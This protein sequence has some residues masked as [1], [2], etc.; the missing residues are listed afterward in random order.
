MRFTGTSPE[1]EHSC[2]ILNGAGNSITL[3]AMQMYMV[4][5][6]SP[7]S[8]LLKI[9]GSLK[10]VSFLPHCFIEFL[11]F[12]TVHR[13]CQFCHNF[14]LR[15]HLN[16]GMAKG[17]TKT[18]FYYKYRL[19]LCKST[20]LASPPRVTETCMFYFWQTHPI[21]WT[22]QA[23]PTFNL[24]A[25]NSTSYSFLCLTKTDSRGQQSN[26]LDHKPGWRNPEAL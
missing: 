11:Y 19:R 22:P 15:N 25:S 23:H 5:I 3:P 20:C 13:S 14:S 26:L 2:C 10:L 21:W 16:R 4:I 6:L 24:T 17:R 12:D 18:G 1:V 8:L 9:Q 7:A